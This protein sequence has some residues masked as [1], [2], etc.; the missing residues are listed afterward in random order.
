[1]KPADRAYRPIGNCC[2]CGLAF[3]GSLSGLYVC[4]PLR[5]MSV[6]GNLELARQIIMLISASTLTA[7]LVS[8]PLLLTARVSQGAKVSLFS[9]D[10]P[11]LPSGVPSL[12]QAKLAHT[13]R[14]KEVSVGQTGDSVPRKPN[15]APSDS[16]KG[17]RRDWLTLLI[18]E[19][20][21]AFI[22]SL[23]PRQIFHSVADPNAP[24]YS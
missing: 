16:G 1:M 19:A 11:K 2:R 14:V 15:S 12:R 6:A 22:S 4:P 9:L 7:I 10:S 8:P 13:I 5:H 18:R 17:K 21:S 24:N 23:S 3:S 20:L